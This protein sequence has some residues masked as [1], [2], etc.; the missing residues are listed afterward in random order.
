MISNKKAFAE[1]LLKLVLALSLLRTDPENYL[2]WGLETRLTGAVGILERRAA[3]LTDYPYANRKAVMPL[4]ED[5]ARFDGYNHQPFDV[6]AYLF[7]THTTTFNPD[8]GA[9]ENQTASHGGGARTEPARNITE[10]PIGSVAGTDHHNSVEDL[11]LNG[12]IF[13]ESG[14]SIMEQNLADLADYGEAAA[15]S[16][17]YQ[18]LKE[19]PAEPT[20]SPLFDIFKCERPG[21]SCSEAFGYLTAPSPDDDEDDGLGGLIEWDEYMG[22]KE[23]IDES[24]LAVQKDAETTQQNSTDPELDN[25]PIVIQRD[26]VTAELTQEV[27]YLWLFSLFGIKLSSTVGVTYGNVSV[28]SE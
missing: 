25:D 8:L 9:S 17:I 21:S 16:L 19:E 13:T 24:A 5:L 10:S 6:Q 1:Q 27:S 15:A 4:I 22:R 12:D 3:P 20:E 7:T 26:P 11:F 28:W 18:S 14:A 23:T 2:E